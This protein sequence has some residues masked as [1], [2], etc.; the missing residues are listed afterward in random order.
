MGKYILKRIGRSILS[1]IAIMIFT[2]ILIYSL[3]NKD[4]LVAKQEQYQ[5][6]SN[7]ERLILIVVKIS[8][9]YLKVNKNIVKSRLAV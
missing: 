7:N 6:T 8:N 3:M 5:K 4:T 9:K 2:I 1:L